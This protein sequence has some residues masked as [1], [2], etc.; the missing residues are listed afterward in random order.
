MSNK[1]FLVEAPYLIGRDANYKAGEKLRK[2][3]TSVTEKDEKIQKMLE[4][5]GGY[6]GN[7]DTDISI[8][9]KTRKITF[10]GRVSF[11]DEGFEKCEK[12]NCSLYQAISPSLALYRTICLFDNP[13][14]DCEGNAGYKV[15]WTMLLLHKKTQNIIAVREWK[16]AFGIG[17]SYYRTSDVPDSLKKDLKL[18]LET[19]LSDKSPH[20]YDGL[21]A[22][23]VA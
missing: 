4:A 16:G 20:P 1:R 12:T 7:V 5:Q 9:L 8:N 17:M 15:P 3:F 21:V 2:A 23:S 18:F 11:L 13:H 14:V 19:I 6:C 22:G 10:D